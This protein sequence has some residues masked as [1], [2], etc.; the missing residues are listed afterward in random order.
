MH[1]HTYR[2]E[3]STEVDPS[4]RIFAAEASEIP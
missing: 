2:Y 3:Q 4:C 1:R